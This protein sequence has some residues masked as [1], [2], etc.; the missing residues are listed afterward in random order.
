[1]YH[2][3]KYGVSEGDYNLMLTKQDDA[4]AI[5]KKISINK[6]LGIDHD[7]NTGRIRGLLCDKCNAMLGMADDNIEVL[8]S[9]ISYLTRSEEELPR[10]PL[11]QKQLLPPEKWSDAELV[12]I[13][14]AKDRWD[15]ASLLKMISDIQ[16]INPNRS[17]A[18]IRIRLVYERRSGDKT[19]PAVRA[20]ILERWT[21]YIKSYGGLTSVR[22]KDVLAAVNN[23]LVLGP[24]FRVG[25]RLFTIESINIGKLP[26]DFDWHALVQENK[27]CPKCEQEKS[28]E[29]FGYDNKTLDGLKRY[30]LQCRNEYVKSWRSVK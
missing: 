29:L 17:V 12:I 7:H 18:A 8:T 27:I 23:G 15:Q 13:R 16:A 20:R 14:E 10:L 24:R 30:C 22:P 21:S 2:L 19:H 1:M 4:C 5:C 25:P 11:I 6:M 28:K 3:K 9:A 26:P